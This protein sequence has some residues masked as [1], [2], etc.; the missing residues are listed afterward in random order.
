MAL[1]EVWV[2]TQHT[3]DAVVPLCA[4]MAHPVPLRL[5]SMAVE[6]GPVSAAT[7]SGSKRGAGSTHPRAVMRRRFGLP[8]Q[9]RLF[10]F[11]FDLNASIHRKNPQSALAAFRRAF[12]ADAWGAHQVGLVVKVQRPAEANLG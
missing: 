8:E 4:G 12:P 6:L 7:G 9:A 1:D 5:M 11:A 10:C 3:R 2:S